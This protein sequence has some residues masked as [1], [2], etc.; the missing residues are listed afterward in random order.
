MYDF[1]Q[2][3]PLNNISAPDKRWKACSSVL[4][5]TWVN[6]SPRD[7]P[8]DLSFYVSARIS[9]DDHIVALRK[10]GANAWVASMPLAKFKKRLAQAN[11]ETLCDDIPRMT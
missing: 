8:F 7:R 11:R 3:P 4:L 1:K 6:G 5:I 10:R 2:C 9:H